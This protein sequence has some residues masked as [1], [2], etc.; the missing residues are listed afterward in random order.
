MFRQ[1]IPSVKS[2]AGKA[3]VLLCLT[4][5]TA[6]VM[7]SCSDFFE[8]DSNRIIYAD[9][10]H[11]NNPSDTLYSMV[12]I[13]TK[14][15]A[16]ADRTIL[17]GEM[18]GDPVAINEHTAADLRNLALVEID[19][20]NMYNN[21]SDYYAVINNCNYYIANADTA[22]KN[23]RNEKIFLKEYAAAKSIRAWTYLQLALNYGEVPFVT[24]PIL[25]KEQAE[26]DYPKMRLTEI[27]DWLIADI[28][29]LADVEVPGY[30]EIRG[31]N[32][33]LLFFPIYIVLGD[34]NLWAGHYKEAAI[35]YY[36][37]ISKRN[38]T[39]S[40]YPTGS[41]YATFWPDGTSNFN[42]YTGIYVNYRLLY[43]DERY[44]NSSELITL[45]PGDSIPS[46]GNYSQ[47]RNLFNSTVDNNA[48]FSIEVSKAMEEL[49]SS[50]TCTY[51][52]KNEEGKVTYGVVPQGIDGLKN[53]DLRLYNTLERYDN[54]IVN[55]ERKDYQNVLKY[56]SRN[57]HIYRRQMIYLR[58]AEAMNNAGYPH[59]AYYVLAS[60]VN[61]KL[62]QD[63]IMKYYPTAQDTA[64]LRRFNFPTSS[65]VL[66]TP[67]HYTSENTCGIHDLGCGWSMQNPDYQLPFDKS[68]V[69]PE[70][71]YY[72]SEA[73]SLAQY[74]YQKWKV[75]SLLLNECGL[76]TCFEGTRFYD[77]MRFS[78]RWNKPSILA[79][80]VYARKGKNSSIE[81]EI[82]VNLRNPDNWYLHWNGKIGIA[83]IYSQS[84]SEEATEGADN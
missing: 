44:D 11:L 72:L 27:C 69:N 26:R 62:I 84:S 45:I 29:P 65:Y 12:G 41:T 6:G 18:R 47:L 70:T 73:D 32:S 64:F 56:Y 19:A 25:T 33:H 10:S 59:F 2:C 39:N 63:S 49:S 61:N 60:G 42:K 82:N 4:L 79:D 68:L 21:P 55:G 36:N 77:L 34:L 20:D 38:G 52:Q 66:R 8:Q 35:N 74:E 57:I 43:R 1:I 17:L 71:G 51:I 37:Y 9:D 16:L 53:G 14:L 5:M 22:K 30:G 50:Q 31:L 23:N 15:Q 7:S 46:E 40:A 81:G 24:T 76:E 78:M 48:L 83:P 67:A 54:T 80:K 58:L 75:D 13:L 28:A 3:M